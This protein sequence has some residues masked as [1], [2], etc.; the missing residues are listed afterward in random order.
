MIRQSFCIACFIENRTVDGFRKAIEA[1]ARMGCPAFELWGRE[2]RPFDE[3]CRMSRDNGMMIASMCGA[4]SL[5]A[6]LNT[7]AHHVAIRDQLRKSLEVAR[8]AGIPNLVFFAGNRYGVSDADCLPI[9]FARSP[10]GS[11]PSAIFTPPATRGGMR[12]TRRRKSNTRPCSKRFGKPGMTGLS[13][14][15]SCRSAT[16]FRPWNRLS[17]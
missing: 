4:A 5:T 13:A 2:N 11:T 3:I 12:L 8:A 17:V 7:R 14:T 6:G 1:A 16:S 10:T 15:S 9:V